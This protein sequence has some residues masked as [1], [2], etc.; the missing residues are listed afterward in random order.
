M[1]LFHYLH[2]GHLNHQALRQH[3]LVIEK[4]LDMKLVDKIFQDHGGI[5]T[6]EGKA[7]LDGREFFTTESEDCLVCEIP[8][9]YSKAIEFIYQVAK[10]TGCDIATVEGGGSESAEQFREG[11]LKMLEMP[12]YPQPA[13]SA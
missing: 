5:S 1:S 9:R 10:Q 12:P 13:Q 4:P 7:I 11:Y 8:P 3:K 2:L 6:P